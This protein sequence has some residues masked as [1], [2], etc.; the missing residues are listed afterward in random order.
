MSTW[1]PLRYAPC[2][3]RTSKL[4]TIVALAMA[5]SCVTETPDPFSVDVITPPDVEPLTTEWVA[6]F[7]KFGFCDELAL[8]AGMPDPVW[9][10]TPSE[11]RRALKPDAFGDWDFSMLPGEAALDVRAVDA[12]GTPLAARCIPVTRFFESGRFR[13]F[14]L[15]PVPAS[16]EIRQDTA[17]TSGSVSR[18]IEVVVTDGD[19]SPVEGVFVSPGTGLPLSRTDADGLAKISTPTT[20][21]PSDANL[22]IEA[23]GVPGV[24]KRGRAAALPEAQ[25][26][27]TTFN[28]PLATGSGSMS[29]LAGAEDV[30]VVLRPDSPG[31]SRIEVFRPPGTRPTLERIATATTAGLGPIAV[32]RDPRDGKFDI[33]VGDED[34]LV[35]LHRFDPAFRTLERGGTLDVSQFAIGPM[36]RFESM[37]MASITATTGTDLILISNAMRPTVSHLPSGAPGAYL[38]ARAL[39]AM[40]R[41]APDAIY[42]G[43]LVGDDRLDGLMVS[44]DGLTVLSQAADGRFEDTGERI[45]D[46]RGPAEIVSFD[47][48]TD[49]H[50]DV[51]ILDA[52]P[53]RAPQAMVF[54]GTRDGLVQIASEPVDQSVEQLFADD[55]NRDGRPD[56]L[57]L[58]RRRATH[59]VLVGDGHGL[60]LPVSDCAAIGDTAGGYAV[61]MDQDGVREWVT[62]SRDARE[63][64][65]LSLPAR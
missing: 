50:L 40:D 42:F 24:P 44:G 15:A 57:A 43:A 6:S 49:D 30:V 2:R 17:L 62:F 5:A 18:D 48:Q 56:V 21:A 23:Y 25:C 55:L 31:V 16:V 59:S 63:L 3:V 38:D 53:G 7:Y 19:G 60:M 64:I 45:A 37:Q 20:T 13:L 33:A 11:R 46:V 39:L 10:S 12:E 58:S 41:A 1:A 14:P 34:G 47:V 36:P 35:H 9:T 22:L 61:D 32:G 51:L 28:T 8:R 26:P 27:E 4:S 65:V 52:P 29:F 54:R